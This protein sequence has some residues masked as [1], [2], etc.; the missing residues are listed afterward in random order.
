MSS[1]IH[2]SKHFNLVCGILMGFSGVC[3]A[4]FF[5]AK[6]LDYIYSHISQFSNILYV[7]VSLVV[8]KWALDKLRWRGME[9]RP[10]RDIECQRRISRWIMFLFIFGGAVPPVRMGRIYLP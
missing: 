2:N 5:P 3:A 1:F 10:Q 8:D 9:G 7:L 4:C 6:F